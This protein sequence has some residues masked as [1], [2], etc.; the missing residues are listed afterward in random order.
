MGEWQN[1]CRDLVGSIPLS[2]F[3]QVT[4]TLAL[5]PIAKWR[6]SSKAVWY[7]SFVDWRNYYVKWLKLAKPWV[8]RSWR[9]SLSCQWPRYTE[10]LSLLSLSIY[11]SYYIWDLFIVTRHSASHVHFHVLS[12]I[13]RGLW[14][15]KRWWCIWWSFIGVGRQNQTSSCKNGGIWFLLLWQGII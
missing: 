9:V 8:A 5:C 2:S 7:A 3:K 4:L 6:M 14:R 11:S 13:C 12:F 10:I 1:V 15:R